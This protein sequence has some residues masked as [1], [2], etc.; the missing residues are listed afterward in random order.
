VNI[1][2]T[3]IDGISGHPADGVKVTIVSRPAGGPPRRLGGL[4]DAQGNFMYSSGV[5]RLAGSE[6]YT[7]EL[8]V[9]AYFTSLGI[10][11]R[12]KQIALLV[13]I[14]NTEKDYRIGTLITP[15]A[16]ATWGVDEGDISGRAPG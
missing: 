10:V 11:A 1:T 6:G 7:V 9:D 2:V 3:V 12:Y 5:E 8:D 13:R 14:L 16:H 4:T 15:F